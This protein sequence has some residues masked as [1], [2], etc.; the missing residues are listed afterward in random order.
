MRN[1]DPGWEKS[2]FEINISDHFCESLETVFTVKN[3]LNIL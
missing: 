3:T 2:Q 1:P